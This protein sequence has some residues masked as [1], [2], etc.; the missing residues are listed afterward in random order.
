MEDVRQGPVH[1]P[2]PPNMSLACPSNIAQVH[3]GVNL[4]LSAPTPAHRRIPSDEALMRMAAYTRVQVPPGQQ[5][6]TVFSPPASPAPSAP[7]P[8]AVAAAATAEGARKLASP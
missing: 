7:L 5:L 3:G 6:P 2:V 8:P 1:P 4:R